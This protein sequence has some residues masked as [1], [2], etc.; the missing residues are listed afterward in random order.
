[1]VILMCFRGGPL[2]GKQLMYIKL[3]GLDCLFSLPTLLSRC[4]VAY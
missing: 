4:R 3:I 2:G 1:M